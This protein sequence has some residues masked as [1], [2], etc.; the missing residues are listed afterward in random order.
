MTLD[1]QAL[2]DE[3]P[4]CRERIHLN[5]AGAGLMPTP[6]LSAIQD[7]FD[8]ESQIGGYEAYR[9]RLGDINQ[10]YGDVAQ[11]LGT[12]PRN[13]AFVENATVAFSQALSAIPFASG[14]VI[15]TS[16]DDYISNQIM[17]LSLSRRMD[18][19]I[20]RA[21]A[22]ESGG[23]DLD[24]MIRLMDEHHPRLVTLTHMPTNSG[25]I[26]P[27]E[28]IGAACRE[29]NVLYLVD[30]CQTL[31]QRP[32]DV[33]KIHCD[34]LCA[35]SR[36]FLRGPR[37]AGFLYV[38][39]SALDAGMEPLFIDMRGAHW[40]DPDVYEPVDS[41]KRFENWEF[42]YALV[43]GTGAAARYANQVGIGAIQKRACDL[44]A[45]L[46]EQLQTHGLQVLDRGEEL[47]AIVTVH[48]PGADP[49]ELMNRLADEKINGSMS[50]RE[51]AVIDYDRK[52][53]P[54]ALRLS[55]HYYNTEEELQIASSFLKTVAS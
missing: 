23:V 37:G 32:M 36:K 15:L 48:I 9:E 34:F 13:I 19:Q 33:S 42:A 52:K 35:T 24:A 39:D 5:N 49:D 30:A 22:Q 55:P 2:R 38:S 54:W 12:G 16:E 50:P 26:Q 51:Y 4:G 45:S 41:A 18:I 28:R 8:L 3:T 31:G 6:V 14:D 25:L 53:V 17:F 43:L 20:I 1:L 47:G 27:V 46:R 11:L 29:R 44:A 7:H 21:P 10:C 40:T